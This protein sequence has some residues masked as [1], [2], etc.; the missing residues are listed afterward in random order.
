MSETLLTKCDLCGC[1]VDWSTLR[2][3]DFWIGERGGDIHRITHVVCEDPPACYARTRRPEHWRN[4]GAAVPVRQEPR[5]GA[6]LGRCLL[7]DVAASRDDLDVQRVRDESGWFEE[8]IC[9]D[10]EA[11]VQRQR[12]STRIEIPP[13]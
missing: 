6:L 12:I 1:L 7:C 5:E 8:V 3:R 10:A 13:F 4:V 11:C 9:R 2:A